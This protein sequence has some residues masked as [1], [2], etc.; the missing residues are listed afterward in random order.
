[1]AWRWA[2]YWEPPAGPTVDIWAPTDGLMTDSGQG[3]LV[4]LPVAIGVAVAGMGLEAMRVPVA[5]LAACSVPLLWV[6]GRRVVG[7]GAAT[8]AAL[9]L[10]VSPVFLVYGR[11]ATLVG[12]SLV[13]LLLSALALVRVLEAGSGEGWRWRREGLLAGSMLLGIYAYAPVRLFWPLAIG[14]LGWEAMRHRERRATLLRTALLCALV[15]PVATMVL[16]WL[17]A[18]EP[19]PVAA[20]V[21]YFHARGEQLVAMSGDPG[22][23]ERYLRDGG[24]G[25]D[26]GWVAAGR[27]VGQNAADLGNLL[28]D[29]GTAPAPTDYWNERGRFWPWFFLPLATIGALALMREGRRAEARL[30]LV[31]SPLLLCAGLALP[32][33]LTS[34]VHI[35]RLAP[36]LPFAVLLAAAGVWTVAGW[37]SGL[38]RWAGWAEVGRWVAPVLARL[39]RWRCGRRRF[40]SAAGRCWWRTRRWATTSSGCM[41]RRIASIWMG[42]IGLSSLGGQ[43]SRMVGISGR[44]CCGGGRWERWRRGSWWGRA[45]GCGSWRRRLLGGFLTHG[46]GR[47]ARGRRIV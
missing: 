4:G 41:W 29:R 18:P 26:P 24:F 25:G 1:T 44:R 11:T 34:R 30:V 37:L 32:L 23:A 15:V 19:D 10:A 46:M 22:A 47:G 8:L 33:L 14:L 6:L 13:P 21:G 7:V 12:V 28:L 3:P 16:E 39:R 38:G 2:T 36:V 27:L 40:G 35:G 20:A 45:S 43:R 5:L 17:A 31:L 42:S 9:L